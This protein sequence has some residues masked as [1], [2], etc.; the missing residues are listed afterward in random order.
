MA[1]EN[2][3]LRQSDTLGDKVSFWLVSFV[4]GSHQTT[5]TK[6]RQITIVTW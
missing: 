4:N 5:L 3:F 1:N 6:H 2:M